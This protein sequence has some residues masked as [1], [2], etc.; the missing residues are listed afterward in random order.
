MPRSARRSFAWRTPD[1]HHHGEAADREGTGKTA[2]RILI[3]R[4]CECALSA[5]SRIRLTTPRQR[6]SRPT[7]L[8]GPPK[9][10]TETLGEFSQVRAFRAVSVHR[11]TDQYALK[12]AETG[13]LGTCSNRDAHFAGVD[14]GGRSLLRTR[15]WRKSLFARE[16][17]G[18]YLSIRGY[19]P[20]LRR[21]LQYFSV[22][23]AA[24]PYSREEGISFSE[25]VIFLPN[26]ETRP[27]D[28]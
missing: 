3:R 16:N 8:S 4:S 26:R 23:Y 18:N 22:C 14:G 28:W 6:A 25:Q 2:E 15:L 17:T 19:Q 10:D 5:T 27:G 12:T 13:A 24:I 21:I 11:F 9:T 1:V 7:P 20:L